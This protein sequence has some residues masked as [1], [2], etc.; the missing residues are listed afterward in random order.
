MDNK[1]DNQNIQS[2]NN[3]VADGV[4]LIENEL[5]VIKKQEYIYKIR[6]TYINKAVMS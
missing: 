3:T 4:L 2:N 5:Q 6:Y 1:D